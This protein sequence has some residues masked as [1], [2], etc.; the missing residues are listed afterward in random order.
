[1]RLNISSLRALLPSCISSTNFT[2]SGLVSGG[3]S[4]PG[5]INTQFEYDG[6]SWTAGGN[7]NTVLSFQANNAYSICVI[8][9]L[10]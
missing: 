5:L 1:M 9:Q 6:S 3:S 7:L 4:D 2:I 10:L 8:A